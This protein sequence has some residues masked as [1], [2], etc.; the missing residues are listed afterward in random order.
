MGDL[1]SLDID[2]HDHDHVRRLVDV[3]KYVLEW[4]SLTTDRW[5]DP[6]FKGP[7]LYLAIVATPSV[8]AYADPMGTNR[9]PVGDCRTVL[10]DHDAFAAAAERVATACDGAVVVSVDGAIHEQ[11]VRFRNPATREDGYAAWMG[12]RHM[13]ALDTSRQESVVATLTLSQESGRVTVFRDGE[14]ESVERAAIASR[15]RAA[16][17]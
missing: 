5:D 15:W 13:S 16:D 1:G 3:S 2:Y 10:D 17:E 8:A 7:G 6:V 9:W 4:L 11:M 12:S 14:Y